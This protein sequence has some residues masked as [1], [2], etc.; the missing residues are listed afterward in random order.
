MHD[1]ASSNRNKDITAVHLNPMVAAGR[2]AKMVAAPVLDYI[3]ALAIF[4]RQALPPVEPVIPARAAFSISAIV[5]RLT[6]VVTAIDLTSYVLPATV[7]GLL[8]ASAIV[9]VAVATL[10]SL[11]YGLISGTLRKRASSRDQGHCH[12]GAQNHLSVHAEPR[13]VEK[14]SKVATIAPPR[15]EFCAL[16]HTH[17]RRSPTGSGYRRR[18]RD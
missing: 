11:I 2:R 14:H 4:G 17:Q 5:V 16:A 8:I 7:L 13:S 10:I 3:S 15:S 6:P 18:I 12:D 9:V 1:E